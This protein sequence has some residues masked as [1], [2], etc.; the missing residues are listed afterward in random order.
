MAYL[1]SHSPAIVHRDLKTANVLLRGAGL[2]ARIC[3]FG[4][5]KQL[6]W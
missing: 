5:A 3:D 1:H 2:E 6:N 4:F